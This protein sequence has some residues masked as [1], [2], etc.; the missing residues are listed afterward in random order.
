M[1][2]RSRSTQYR[3][4]RLG[5]DGIGILRQTETCTAN[6]Q[7]KVASA[8]CRCAERLGFEP[9]RILKLIEAQRR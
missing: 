6:A 7:A 2:S 5:R 3:G 1:T 8:V 4:D 9:A